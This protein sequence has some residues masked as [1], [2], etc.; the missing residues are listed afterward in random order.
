[1]SSQKGLHLR[2]EHHAPRSPG[3]H[4]AHARYVRLVAEGSALERTIAFSDAVF[5]IAMTIL[6]LEL[7]VP[8]TEPGRLP[9]A[10]LALLPEYLTFALSFVVIGVIWLSHHRKF[11]VIA[12]YDQ[13]LLR[14]NLLLLL[15][16]VSLGLPTAILGE[17]GDQPFAAALYAALISATGLVM[18]G[19]WVYAW[20]RRLLEP[21]VDAGVF[22]YVL[23][24]SLPIPAVFLLSIPVAYLLGPTAAEISWSIAIPASYVIPHFHR[25]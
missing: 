5:A 18:S 4:S 20:R 13:T 23:A 14:L 8:Q 10:V 1:M 24:Q 19:I 17:Y 12:R 21:K 11:S 22:R 2:S 15:L 6:V 9:A 7:H 16:V 3:P 25:Q